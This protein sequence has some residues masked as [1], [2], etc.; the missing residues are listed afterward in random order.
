M[1]TIRIKET[2]GTAKAAVIIGV[3]AVVCAMGAWVLVPKSE[4][5]KH[6]TA[7]SPG[8]P[9]TFL[10]ISQIYDYKLGAGHK[11]NVH[12]SMPAEY[13]YP[14]ACKTVNDAPENGS[15]N[16]G[17]ILLLPEGAAL[18]FGV[19]ADE[20]TANEKNFVLPRSRKERKTQNKQKQPVEDRQ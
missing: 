13:W 9:E 17:T 16:Q 15:E 2:K 19:K 4:S 10:N 7:E 11:I 14:K 18:R 8:Y 20:A 12:D 6:K 5:P 3:L 1:N